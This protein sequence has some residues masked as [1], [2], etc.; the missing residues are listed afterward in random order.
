MTQIDDY[1]QPIDT[2]FNK[3]R[4]EEKSAYVLRGILQGVI[5]NSEVN[6]AEM[7]YLD[8]W[9]KKQDNVEMEGDALDL[10]CCV[11]DILEDGHVSDEEMN[12]IKDLIDTILTYG[13]PSSPYEEPRINEFFGI[14]K[15]ICSDKKLDLREINRIEGWIDQNADLAGRFPV[16]PVYDRIQA[17]K[18]DGKIDQF[19]TDDLH[20]LLVDLTGGG[21]QRSDIH[22]SVAS[23]FSDAID[24][25]EHKNQKLCFTGKFLFGTRKQCEEKAQIL[26]ATTTSNI[27]K[28]VDVIVIGTITSRDWMFDTYGRKIETAIN[29]RNSHGFPKILSEEQWI[30]T[31]KLD[32]LAN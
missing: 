27:S 15:G 29:L 18:S 13:V 23:F 9:V 16:E 24:G 5:A 3:R 10:V 7:L 22:G 30:S 17:A 19:E 11:K 12:D 8:E 25:F 2:A 21:D 26:G 32:Y 6:K 4:N 14:L 20:S 31:I 1:G 28:Q